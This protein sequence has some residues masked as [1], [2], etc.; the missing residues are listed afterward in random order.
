[1][2]LFAFSFDAFERA[3]VT[4]TQS[5]GNFLLADLDVTGRSPRPRAFGNR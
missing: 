1:M 5:Q 3:Y 2:I 4:Q